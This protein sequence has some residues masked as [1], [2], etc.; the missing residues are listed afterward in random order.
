MLS[1]S[2]QGGGQQ[3]GRF[4]RAGRR[5]MLFH[6][7]RRRS[8]RY[9]CYPGLTPGLPVFYYPYRTDRNSTEMLVPK[10]RRPL[11]LCRHAPNTRSGQWLPSRRTKR[12]CR[13]RR[14]WPRC[15]EC[16]TGTCKACILQDLRRAGLLVGHRGSDGGYALARPAA[17]I[18][19]GDVLR[20][21]NGSIT[22]VRG[23][24]IHLA[25]YDG[26]ATGLGASVAD[27]LSN[28]A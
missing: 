11:C 17:E 5:P 12:G 14:R 21:V 1:G 22:T 3:H 15:R 23:L 2:G 24:P 28:H 10:L 19:V 9:L 7:T 26:A 18:S 13:R 20:A 16:R 6:S 8:A 25:T 4:Q 27:L